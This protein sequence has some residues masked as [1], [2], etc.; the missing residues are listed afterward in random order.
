MEP[1]DENVTQ[2]D[3][4]ATPFS[5]HKEK[6]ESQ[7]I[8]PQNCRHALGWMNAG[9]IWNQIFVIL[10]FEKKSTIFMEDCLLSV[11]AKTKTKKLKWTAAAA[12]R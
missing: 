12:G 3:H 4:S 5:K 1:S 8:A 10:D 2:S 7:N 11:E 9:T 6:N